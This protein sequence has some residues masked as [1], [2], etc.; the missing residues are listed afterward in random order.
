MYQVHREN[1]KYCRELLD[2]LE[3]HHRE[4]SR[5]LGELSELTDLLLKID[6]SLGHLSASPLSPLSSQFLV[7]CGFVLVERA[8]LDEDLWEEFILI[9]RQI[10]MAAWLGEVT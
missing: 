10:Y 2:S 3:R 4:V 1:E 7:N 5:E 6:Q 9:L 8:V